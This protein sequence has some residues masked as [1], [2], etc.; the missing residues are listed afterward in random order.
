MQ[1]LYPIGDT[2]KR[3]RSHKKTR[4]IIPKHMEM[5]I[6]K[7]RV[8]R[9]TA[10]QQEK[11][12]ANVWIAIAPYMYVPDE[13]YE[14]LRSDTPDPT[15]IQVYTHEKKHIQRQEVFGLPVGVYV[16]WGLYLSSA[17][18]RVN[19]EL[20]AVRAEMEYCIEAGLRFDIVFHAKSLSGDLYWNCISYQ[21][22]SRKLQD[23][24]N[25]IVSKRENPRK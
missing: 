16:W 3:C 2:R 17:K 12:A 11:Y 5:H 23:I 21:E 22:A 4:C 1:S 10:K 18:F 14:S 13:G 8:R 20:H 6:E 9:K 7:H 24:W 25:D 15:D 19:E